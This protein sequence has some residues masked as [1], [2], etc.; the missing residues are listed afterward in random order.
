M[1]RSTSGGIGI[2][3]VLPVL[4]MMSF[5]IQWLYGKHISRDYIQILLNNK[6]QQ[7]FIM[8][9]TL[10]QSLLSMIPLLKYL[11]KITLLPPSNK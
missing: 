9:C 11:P 2:R 5:L 8:S 10:G 7:V 1:A 6:D 3:Y 4:W